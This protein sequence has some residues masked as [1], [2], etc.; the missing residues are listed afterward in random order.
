MKTADEFIT[1]IMDS[2]RDMSDADYCDFLEEI[3]SACDAAAQT[4]RE[5]MG[6]E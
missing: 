4:K 6:E 5:E 3:S 2:T 1:E